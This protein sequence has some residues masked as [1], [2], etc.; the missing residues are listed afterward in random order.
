[1]PV[2]VKLIKG[3][4]FTLIELLVVI[5]IIAVLIGLLLPAVQKVREAANRTQCQ[6][7]L[8]QLGVATH[9]FND[10]YGQ[11]PLVEATTSGGYGVY[12]KPGTNGTVFF[13]LLPF[14]E[15]Q[16]L[17]NLAGGSSMNL[18]GQ[19]AVIK[20][21]L[22]PSDPGP[23]NAGSYGGCGAMQSSTVQRDGYPTNNYAANVLV[24]EPRGTS[25]IAAQISDGTSNTVMFAERFRNCSPASGGCTLPA[26]PWNT[27]LNGGDPWASPTF[28]GNNDGLWNLGGGGAN[29]SYGSVGFQGGPSPQQCNWYVTQGPHTQ[30]M[31]VGMGDGSVRNVGGGVSVTTWTAAC[32]P[33]GGD[34]L[35]PDW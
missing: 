21:F 2:L 31:E 16:N 4:G 32:T 22:C 5:A 26:W 25:N 17:Y 18:S 29:I 3:K 19:S 10:S 6:N 28:G 15:Q 1:M 34:I 23:V 8:K 35:G 24:F 9:N 27:Q 30:G 13:Y 33:A 7:N 12:P 11:L 20:T 14:M